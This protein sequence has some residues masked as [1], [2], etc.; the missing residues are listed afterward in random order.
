MRGAGY[1]QDGEI[2]RLGRL[3]SSMPGGRRV[4]AP[5]CDER[6]SFH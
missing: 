6:N 1:L 2:D 4:T 5:R 3:L